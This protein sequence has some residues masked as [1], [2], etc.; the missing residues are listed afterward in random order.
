[1][2]REREG[3]RGA[4]ADV[5]SGKEIDAAIS[6]D[7]KTVA[8]SAEY[9]GP[10]D[11]YTMP[12]DGGLP[13]RRTWDGA[14]AVAGWTPDGRVLVRTQRYSTLPDPKLVAIDSSGDA[15]SF[16]WPSPRKAAYAPDGKTLFLRATTGSPARPSVT[17]A[18]R[19]K[20]SGA[21]TT[22]RKRCL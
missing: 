8:F 7:G 15:R 5:E 3:R 6:P 9:E 11:V 10:L 14:A 18:A 20:T 17:R 4:A 16:R 22:A 1:M 2:V 13:Q 21:M 12:V 19:R